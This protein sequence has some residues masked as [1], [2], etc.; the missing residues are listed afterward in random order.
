MKS[1]LL[2]HNVNAIFTSRAIEHEKTVYRESFEKLRVLKPE[3]E[4]L[5]KVAF[6]MKC[7]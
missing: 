5:R 3:I 4:Y 7:T 6:K 1:E 2:D